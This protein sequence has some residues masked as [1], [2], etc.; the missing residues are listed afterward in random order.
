MS[1][2]GGPNQPQ[3]NFERSTLSAETI[4]AID[5]DLSAST[6][7]GYTSD[8][9]KTFGRR[10]P[11]IL[12]VDAIVKENCESGYAKTHWRRGIL[13]TLSRLAFRIRRSERRLLGDE[14][15]EA[16]NL[17]LDAEGGATE[18]GWGDVMVGWV[19]IAN[20][21]RHAGIAFIAE[22]LD[23]DGREDFADLVEVKNLKGGKGAF[24]GEREGDLAEDAAPRRLRLLFDRLLEPVNSPDSLH[25][26]AVTAGYTTIRPQCD[27]K[28]RTVRRQES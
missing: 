14:F 20:R 25:Y 10:R 5:H 15:S 21:V 26:L 11:G 4:V 17:L 18:A 7:H 1:P 8:G 27:R 22:F 24:A 2:S 9:L 16:A 19:D 12:A 28:Q 13:S 3:S 6:D 23:A